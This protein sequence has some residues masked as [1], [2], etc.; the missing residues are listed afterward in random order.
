M[1]F[2]GRKSND[3]YPHKTAADNVNKTYPFTAKFYRNVA[4]AS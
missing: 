1:D 3:D 2:E 4:A